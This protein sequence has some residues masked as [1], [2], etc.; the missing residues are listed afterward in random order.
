MQSV[1][2]LCNSYKGPNIA[3]IDPDTGR[4]TSLFHPRRQQWKR[5]FRWDGPVLLGRTAIGRAT[6]AVL[7]IN[8]SDAIAAREALIEE[9]FFP[10][11]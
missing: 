2:V 9:G 3:G 11:H 5:H 7:M 8:H 1:C 10:P 4:L 6:I